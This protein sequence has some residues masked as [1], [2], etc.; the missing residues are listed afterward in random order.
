MFDRAKELVRED[1][2][3]VKKISELK[4]KAVEELS[5]LNAELRVLKVKI[6]ELMELPDAKEEDIKKLH[7]Q[8]VNLDAKIHRTKFSYM[9]QLRKILGPEDFKKLHKKHRMKEKD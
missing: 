3:K 5:K 4:V 1:Q 2:E 7:D 9:L 6:H 8:I